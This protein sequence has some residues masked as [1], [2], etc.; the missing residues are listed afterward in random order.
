MPDFGFDDLRLWARAFAIELSDRQIDQLRIYVATMLQWNRR[1][2][3]VSQMDAASILIKHVADS[4]VP[5]T[6]CRQGER[7]VDLGSGAGFPGIPM[8]VARPDLHLVLIE[9]NQKRV[10]FLMEVVRLLGLQQT[11]VVG[12]RLATAAHRSELKGSCTIAISR[13]LSRLGEMLDHARPFLSDGGRV[14]AMKGP[15]YQDELNDLGEAGKRY[16]LQQ[17]VPYHLPDGSRRVL[18]VLC[19]T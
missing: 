18:V 1:V 4:L 5:C 15:S 11:R 9:A 7:V 2:N 8:A 13:A 17:L 3:L 10:T 16:R 12:Q 14:L 19:F 6:L